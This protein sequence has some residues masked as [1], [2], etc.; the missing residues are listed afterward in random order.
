MTVKERVFRLLRTKRELT[1]QEIA[2]ELSLSMPTTLQ[3][4]AELAEAGI[5]E[6]CGAAESV[7][8]RKAK[9]IRLRPQAG[10]SAGINIALHQVEFVVTD[11]LG[12]IRR[13]GTVPLVFR[14]ETDWY[15]QLKDA[16][17][18][19]LQGIENVL[20]AGLSFPGI[21]DSQA[22]QIIQSHIFGLSHVG[23]DR[24]QRSIPYPLAA[25]N[26]ANCACFAEREAGHDS[27]VYVS[28]NES[29]GG[30]VMMNRQLLL[31]DTFQAGEVGHMLLVPGGRACYCGKSGCA[32][33]YLSPKAL[34]Q[35]GWDV[36]LEH[37]A[38]LLT[39]LRMLLN[40]D[41]VVGG[42][43]G[44][45]LDSHWDS[46]CAKAA[47]YDRFARDINYIFPCIQREYSCAAG[48][49]ALALEKFG[50]RILC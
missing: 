39:N 42:K 31:G 5:I 48:A 47:Q 12:Q 26:D 44:V 9:K 2:A 40:M 29:V 17:T 20:C 11:L 13:S 4:V 1:R 3:N 43:I 32:D 50:S 6:E 23:L 46:L 30:A 16:L 35:D 27:F 15:T 14:D 25:G 49:A 38:I 10:F 36:Y 37:L 24:F 45:Q 8:G 33:S 22:G 18:A 7:S 41:A 19:F 34:E 21:I 28:L